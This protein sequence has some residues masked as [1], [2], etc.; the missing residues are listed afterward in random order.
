[1]GSTVR[2]ETECQIAVIVVYNYLGSECI[3]G[4][5][6]PILDS[7]FAQLYTPYRIIRRCIMERF[8]VIDTPV[9]GLEN[10]H[11]NKIGVILQIFWTKSVYPYTYQYTYNDH[12]KY[13]FQ[14]CDGSSHG[15]CNTLL[16]ILTG[17]AT[18]AP[19]FDVTTT[20]IKT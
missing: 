7:G 14:Q 1:M 16:A 17:E 10:I 4:T 15:C 19:F 9:F 18:L 6:G 12:Y 11:I 20:S 13:Q 5:F 8:V 2:I 3:V